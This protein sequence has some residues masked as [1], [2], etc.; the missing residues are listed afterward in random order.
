[1]CSPSRHIKFC[2]CSPDLDPDEADWTL[3]RPNR[4][5]IV[6]GVIMREWPDSEDI[7][8]QKHAYNHRILDDLN[9][10]NCFDFEYEPEEGDYLSI[11]NFLAYHIYF[12][13]GRWIAEHQKTILESYGNHLFAGKLVEPLVIP[14]RAES[15]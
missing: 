3:Y 13:D 4:K 9:N 15:H 12:R 7:A 5:A 14:G 1:M 10:Q 2:T 11:H 6:F 8:R